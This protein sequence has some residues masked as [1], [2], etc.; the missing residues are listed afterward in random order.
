[1]SFACED[2]NDTPIEKLEESKAFDISQVPKAKLVI[3]ASVPK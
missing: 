1:M 3:N 2:K